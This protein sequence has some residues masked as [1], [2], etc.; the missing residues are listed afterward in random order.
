MS[1]EIRSGHLET[2]PFFF[3]LFAFLAKRYIVLPQHM[4]PSLYHPQIN[5]DDQ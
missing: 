4:L 5:G 2:G 1:L 3:F